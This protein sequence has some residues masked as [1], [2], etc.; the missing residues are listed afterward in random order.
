MADFTPG[1]ATPDSPTTRAVVPV[2]LS[3][4][5]TSDN[6][7]TS[8]QPLTLD[9]G[10]LASSPGLSEY[11]EHAAKGIPYL[12]NLAT[13]LESRGEF[14][15]ALL[16]WERI[17]DSASPN[18]TQRQLASDAITRIKPTLPRWN[19]DPIAEFTLIIQIG[20]TR[21]ESDAMAAA[22][23]ELEKFLRKNSSDQIKFIS[24]VTF[25]SSESA[26]EDGPIAVSFTSDPPSPD[27]SYALV[28]ST[29][30]ADNTPEALY[31]ALLSECYLLVVNHLNSLEDTVAPAPPVHS[32]SPEE[33]FSRN[34]TRLHWRTFALSLIPPPQEDVPY[35][36]L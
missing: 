20:S 21:P 34:I 23:L 15:R 32:V 6:R 14:E 12:T 18:E 3:S 4:S 1:L 16:C 9:P 35:P 2:N 24:Q 26:P 13:E 8:P 10:D 5:N 7:N 29:S 30:P 25:S 19:I 33:Q 11:I 31:P 17:L 36:E 22:M 28:R 27:T